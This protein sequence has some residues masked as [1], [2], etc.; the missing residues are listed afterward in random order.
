MIN[1]NNFVEI[2]E[3]KNATLNQKK[4]TEVNTGVIFGKTKILRKLINEIK[5]DETTNEKYLTSIFKLS[6]EFNIKTGCF[7]SKDP[8][9]FFGVN[10]I[11]D[12]I[13]ATKIY[14]QRKFDQL[15][16]KGTVIHSFDNTHIFGELTCG[17][18]VELYP[19]VSFLEK[20]K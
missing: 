5:T 15:I 9:S 10:T 17:Y 20:Q 7:K 11:T 18:D 12:L 19:N 8:S 6:K 4:L 3:E 14:K 2:I 1:L 13:Y 16:T